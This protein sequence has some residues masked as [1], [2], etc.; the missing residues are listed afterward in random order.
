MNAELVNH[1][2]SELS[3]EII[4][5]DTISDNYAELSLYVNDLLPAGYYKVK[6]TVQDIL[7]PVYQSYLI[8]APSIDLIEIA[9]NTHYYGDQQELTVNVITRHVADGTEVSFVLIDEERNPIIDEET[10][11]TNINNNIANIEITL[12][13]DLDI[14]TYF[15]EVRVDG[16]L[17]KDSPPYEVTT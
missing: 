15:V 17:P 10:L 2:K 8:D 14:G 12:P 16:I 13:A 6:V 9:P 5:E 11:A 4:D 7:D 3:F 1:D